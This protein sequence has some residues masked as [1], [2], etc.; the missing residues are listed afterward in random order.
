M[1]DVADTLRVD[2]TTPVTHDR[3]QQHFRIVKRPIDWQTDIRFRFL[4]D[5]RFLIFDTKP[6]KCT[7]PRGLTQQ[8]YPLGVGVPHS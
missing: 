6:G 3:E 1:D 8:W 7:I 4:W 2:G 5:Y